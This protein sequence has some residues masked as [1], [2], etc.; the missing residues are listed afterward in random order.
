MA[1]E[2]IPGFTL[3]GVACPQVVLA[4]L[5]SKGSASQLVAVN[6]VSVIFTGLQIYMAPYRFLEGERLCAH[7]VCT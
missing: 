6:F 3:P 2:H 7:S 1:V 4:F 5:L